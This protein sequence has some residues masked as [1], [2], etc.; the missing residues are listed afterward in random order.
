[1]SLLSNFIEITFEG[2][3]FQQSYRSL[4]PA[5]LTKNVSIFQRFWHQLQ[6]SYFEEHLSV[7]ASEVMLQM[8]ISEYVLTHP[9]PSDIRKK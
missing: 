1:M 2:D 8:Q 6:H 9:L 5:V 3:H 4:Q 7:T